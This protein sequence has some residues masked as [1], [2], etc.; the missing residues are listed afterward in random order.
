MIGV[1]DT[2]HVQPL[3][4]GP[5]FRTGQRTVFL[6]VRGEGDAEFLNFLKGDIGAPE[7]GKAAQRAGQGAHQ[8]ERRDHIAGHGFFADALHLWEQ[9]E[10]QPNQRVEEQVTPALRDNEMSLS[11][12]VVT[13]EILGCGADVFVE[14]D[15]PAA[16]VQLQFFNSFCQ[17]AE[18]AEEFLFLFPGESQTVKTAVDQGTV[19]QPARDNE[20]PHHEQDLPGEP[21]EVSRPA[22]KNGHVHRHQRQSEQRLGDIKNIVGERDHELGRADLFQPPQRDGQNPADQ[23]LAQFRDGALSEANQQQLGKK[24]GRDFAQAKAGEAQDEQ[25]RRSTRIIE[26][27]VHNRDQPRVARATEERGQGGED[28]HRAAGA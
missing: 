8:V 24:T 2:N 20:E 6:G 15:A 9:K 4:G 1:S 21:S 22:E 5:R 27:A 26:R 23:I 18:M 12:H 19:S 14:K 11:G 10:Q 3:E 13:L 7:N 16:A 17:A 25:R 28:H